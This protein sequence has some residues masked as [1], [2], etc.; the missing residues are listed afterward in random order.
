M[1][2]NKRQG[3]LAALMRWCSS[4]RRYRRVVQ[5]LRD[6]V[7]LEE[8]G[9]QGGMERGRLY[10]TVQDLLDGFIRFKKG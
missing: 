9:S 4:Q 2:G 8:V 5:D 10:R 3:I 1:Q 7:H 6:E